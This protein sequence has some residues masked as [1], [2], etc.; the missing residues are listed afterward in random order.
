MFQD[1]GRFGRLSRPAR[2]WA[3]KGIRPIVKNRLVR[4][5]TYAFAAI[6]P[7]D[8]AMDS[9]ILPFVNAETMSLFLRTVADR[10]PDDFIL[11]VLDGAGWHKAGEL[12][13]P[14]NMRLHF[15]PPYSPELNPVEHLWDHLRE[16]NFANKLFSS[17]TAV[18]DQLSSS[19]RKAELDANMIQS[20]CGFGY[21]ELNY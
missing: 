15:L 7:K 21:D 20:L 2:C 13:V 12:V 9:L 5:Y 17:M 14:Q 4:E 11:M 8:G 6:S 18:T 19:L 10:H 3:P 16:K 1:E